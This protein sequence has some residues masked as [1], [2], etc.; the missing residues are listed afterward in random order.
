MIIVRCHLEL[1]LHSDQFGFSVFTEEMNFELTKDCT[2][3]YYQFGRFHIWWHWWWW[4]QLW[5]PKRVMIDDNVWRVGFCIIFSFSGTF[6]CSPLTRVQR[7]V[8][9]GILQGGSLSSSSEQH[10]LSH[11]RSIVNFVKPYKSPLVGQNSHSVRKLCNVSHLKWF[12]SHVT[13]YQS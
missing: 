5:G 8:G 7:D 10:K 9:S 4:W 3:D 11:N 12:L 1:E 2:R 13:C 6:W